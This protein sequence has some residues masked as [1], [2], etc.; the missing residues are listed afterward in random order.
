VRAKTTVSF[1]GAGS[2]I[3]SGSGFALMLALTSLPPLI[4]KTTALSEDFGLITIS[5][6]VAASTA[7]ASTIL[8][9]LI[10]K[11]SALPGGFGLTTTSPALAVPAVTSNAAATMAAS[12]F[13]FEHVI[14]LYWNAAEPTYI[15]YRLEPLEGTTHSIGLDRLG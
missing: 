3:G 12:D 6:V 8:P 15:S 7:V 13:I 9:P 5:P 10:V 4:V 1:T 14:G 2:P 11:T